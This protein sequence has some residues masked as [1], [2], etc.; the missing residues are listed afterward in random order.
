MDES[1]VSVVKRAN[2]ILL[3]QFTEM[4]ILTELV[5]FV[6]RLLLTNL[7]ALGLLWGKVIVMLIPRHLCGQSG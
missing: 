5:V 2:D 1:G 6:N 4:K 7:E 3:G